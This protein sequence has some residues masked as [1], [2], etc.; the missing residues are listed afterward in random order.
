[1]QPKVHGN[2]TISKNARDIITMQNNSYARE[3]IHEMGD[4]TYI[5]TY[6]YVHIC[7]YI[8]MFAYE[9]NIQY[10]VN[11]DKPDTFKNI[12]IIFMQI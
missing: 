4:H 2:I 6:T 3:C 9:D 12:Y 11:N 7:T 10:L 8:C 1:M 5:S